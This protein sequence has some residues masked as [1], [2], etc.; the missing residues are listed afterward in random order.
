MDEKDNY[1]NHSKEKNKFLD[2][3]KHIIIK[4]IGNGIFEGNSFYYHTTLD[5][6][7]ELYTKQLNLFW[8]GKQAK[9]RICEIGFNAGH[10][11][12]LM[13]LG[14]DKTPLNFTIF[15][16]GHHLYTKPC[17]EYI[18]LQFPHIIF[19]YIEGDSTVSIP[20]WI[21]HNKYTFDVIH[22]DGGHSEH[23]ISNDLMNADKLICH[24]GII[25][26]DDTNFWHI[27]NYVNKYLLTDKYI[28]LNV[29]KT[30]GY[31]HRIIQKV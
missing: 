3:L 21:N 19:E 20:E 26:I 22:V 15:D 28:E 16:I 23:C 5:L 31:E 8:C 4:N 30:I 24:K 27:N 9:T 6:Y 17:L 13:L 2:D 25:I 1:E 7:P 11:S 10:S 12:M 18:K 29:L 14:R